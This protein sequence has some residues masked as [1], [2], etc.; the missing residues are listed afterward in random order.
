MNNKI[1]IDTNILVYLANKSS[2]RHDETKKIFQEISK[3]HDMWISWQIL[4]EYAV[5]MTRTESFEKPLSPKKVV[6][7]IVKWKGIFHIADEN[8]RVSSNLLKLVSDYSLKGKRIH[9][10]NIVASMLAEEID[11]I[12]TWDT[13]D[14]NTFTEI[15]LVELMPD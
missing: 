15:A 5:V 3:K 12:F 4:R 9:D 13:K 7:D 8:E 6:E 10:A 14:F 2:P 1:F 11:L